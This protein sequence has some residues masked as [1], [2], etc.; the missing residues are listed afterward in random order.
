MA[1]LATIERLAARVGESVSEMDSTQVA[2][3]NEMLEQAS[4]AVRFYAGQAW[5]DPAIAPAVAVT[6]TVAAAARGYLNPEG[7]QMERGDTVTLARD[8]GYSGGP[9]ALLPEERAILSTFK[10]QK[11]LV[12][13]NVSNEFIPTPRSARNGKWR[14]GMSREWPWGPPENGW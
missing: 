9:T 5:P 13:L 1:A 2:M 8:K 3:A 7:Y 11:G 4:A 6:I 12:S 14:E 10:V